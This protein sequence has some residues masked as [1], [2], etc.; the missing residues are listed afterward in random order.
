MAMLGST[1]VRY[2]GPVPPFVL[3]FLLFGFHG[4]FDFTY[5]SYRFLRNVEKLIIK[6]RHKTG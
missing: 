3:M 1:V 2:V 5:R 4:W 6:S